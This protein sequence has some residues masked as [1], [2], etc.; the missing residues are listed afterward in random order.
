MKKKKSLNKTFASLVVFGIFVIMAAASGEGGSSSRSYENDAIESTEDDDS[1]A[2]RPQNGDNPEIVNEAE[3]S[4][5]EMKENDR[6][7]IDNISN[8]AEDVS[9]EEMNE[10]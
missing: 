8:Q 1:Y 6:V 9:D 2:N 3:V 5:K 10:D 7:H 4:E